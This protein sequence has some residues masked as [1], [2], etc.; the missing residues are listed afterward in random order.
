MRRDFV[1][2]IHTSADFKVQKVPNIV[3]AK[4]CLN[5]SRH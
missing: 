4:L 1:L 2:Y 5:V 3:H